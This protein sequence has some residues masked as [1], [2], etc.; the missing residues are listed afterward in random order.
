MENLLKLIR[1]YLPLVVIVTVIIILDQWTKG[2]V[3]ANLAISETWMPI[4]WL[5]PYA[6]IVHWYNTGSAFGMF[7][8][9]GDVFKFLAPVVAL[10]IL[11]YYPQV[12]E[13]DWWMRLALAMQM[14]GALGNFIDR[15]TIGHVTDFISVG[16]FPVWNVADASIT[17]GVGILLLGVYLTERSAKKESA[18]ETPETETKESA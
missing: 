2:L 6:R 9:F 11:Y 7:Q 14:S 12:E 17:V 13:K 16:T 3:R 15:V 8:Q 1:T 18:A 10:L 4:E 5:A